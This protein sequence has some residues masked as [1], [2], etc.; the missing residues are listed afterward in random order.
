MMEQTTNITESCQSRNKVAVK[1]PNQALKI[2]TAIW[3]VTV[4]LGQW[5][6]FYYILAF[7]GSSVLNDNM[8]IWNR[9]E[10]FGVKPYHSGDFAGNLAF[11]AHA[12]G[13]GIIALGGVLQ[14]M[15]QVRKRFPKFHK[16]NGYA[17]VTTVVCLSLSGFYLVW[18]RDPS[19][20]I[21]LSDI[22]TSINGLLIFAF[23]YLTVNRVL[24]KDIKNHRKWAIRLFLVSNAQW[25]LRLGVF[26][27]FVTGTMLGFK[28][29]MGDPFFPMWTFGCF[30]L[31]LVIA[32]LYFYANEKGGTKFKYAISG[33]MVAL[34]ILM[35]LGMLGFTPFLLSVLNGGEIT[36]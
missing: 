27:Y 19:D 7:Y 13:A 9:W 4:L 25:F 12:I 24:K 26:S 30:V 14:I 28:P 10:V 34:S 5:F 31:P 32:E 11:A 29:A 8:E 20:P 16:I 36:F 17:F 23:A 21:K 15:P 1:L 18:F 3:F 2:S 35:V 6:F 22:G 33:V